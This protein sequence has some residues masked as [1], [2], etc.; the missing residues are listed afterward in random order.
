MHGSLSVVTESVTL[1]A[2]IPEDLPTLAGT[3]ASWGDSVEFFGYAASNSLDRWFN[4]CG[5]LSDDSGML[6]VIA[7]GD[8][9]GL[10][11][12]DAIEYGPRSASRAMRI[13]AALLPGKHGHGSG[14]LAQRILADYLFATTLVNRV[15]AATDV[16]NVA[17]W[18][19]LEK[20]G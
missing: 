12:Y 5:C 7:D 18:R 2:V 6:A 17:E 8:L 15:E 16:S 10:V 1:R 14:T 13:G 19:A 11:S 20:A 9:V 4:E 3:F